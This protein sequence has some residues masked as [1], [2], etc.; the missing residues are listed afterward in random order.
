MEQLMGKVNETTDE[1]RKVNQTMEHMMGNKRRRVET[2]DFY[3]KTEY[4]TETEYVMRI[5]KVVCKNLKEENNTTEY[6]ELDKKVLELLIEN[7]RLTNENKKSTNTIEKLWDEIKEL[8]NELNKLQSE[9]NNVLQF[10]TPPVLNPKPTR[11][12]ECFPTTRNRKK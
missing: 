10:E 4:E 1:G 3:V 9:V 7:E 8:N 2:D 12:T 11:K 5:L 6:K